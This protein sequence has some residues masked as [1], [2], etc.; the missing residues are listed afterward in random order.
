MVSTSYTAAVPTPKTGLKPEEEICRE[1]IQLVI[2]NYTTE[3]RAQ[4]YAA[5][6]GISLQ[7]L[8]TTIKRVTGKNV[9]D[10]IAHVVIID[11]KAKLKSTDMTIQEIAYSLN[12]PSASFFGKVFQAAL[13]NESAGIQKQANPYPSPA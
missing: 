10:L 7:H 11:I 8:S 9:L 6:L 4:F 5:K 2:E 3:R 13:G 12:F 1:F